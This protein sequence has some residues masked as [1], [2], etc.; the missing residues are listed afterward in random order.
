M[1]K[2]SLNGFLA[3][4]I[5]YINEIARI[6]EYTGASAKE[7]E[8]GLK[9]DPRIGYGSYLH[10]GAAFAGG[11]LARDTV[12]LTQ[13]IERHQ[14]QLPLIPSIRK[15]NEIHR[16]W[17]LD[18]LRSFFPSL[19][20]ISILILGLTYKPGTDTLRRSHSVQLTERL[21]QEGA[22][23]Q[24]W[25]PAFEGAPPPAL[26]WANS[27][28]TALSTHSVWIF[29]NQHPHWKSI[30]WSAMHLQKTLVLD[31]GGLMQSIL[32]NDPLITYC[33]VGESNL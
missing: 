3:L 2:H 11:T 19:K 30:N 14:L 8:E 33:Q 9:S 10:A 18:Q 6:C 17:S 25:D 7:V 13:E 15:S 23:V 32:V 12:Y 26:P 29:M 28:E 4:S 31:A 27:L 20:G 21:L 24:V 22:V 5:S 16:Q 1:V